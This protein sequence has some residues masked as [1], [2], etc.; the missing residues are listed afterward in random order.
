MAEKKKDALERI[1]DILAGAQFKDGSLDL[2]VSTRS[3]MPVVVVL[4]ASGKTL[5]ALEAIGYG[6]QTIAAALCAKAE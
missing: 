4:H 5:E 3:S 2:T 6:L 1:A